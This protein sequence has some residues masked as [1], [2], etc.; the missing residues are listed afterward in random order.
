MS[1]FCM[2]G[3]HQDMY[4]L[5]ATFNDLKIV[6]WLGLDWTVQMEVLEHDQVGLGSD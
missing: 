4:P 1:S 3:L 6:T 5:G 2:L